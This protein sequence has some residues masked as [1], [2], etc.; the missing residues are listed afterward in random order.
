MTLANKITLLRILLVPLFIIG[1]LMGGDYWPLALFVFLALTDVLDGA[2][3]RLRNQRTVLG[4]FLDPVADKLLLGAAFLVL[5]VQGRVPVWAFVLV[6]SR[7]VLILLGWNIIYILTKTSTVQPRWLGKATTLF[8]MLTVIVC[9]APVSDV[10][11]H[12]TAWG[13]ALVTAASTVDYVWVGGKK[14]NQ[15]G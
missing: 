4:T 15:L 10:L 11:A 2:V 6:F 8:Q 3:A 12:W 14:L 5:S 9:L 7:D 13:M 1:L